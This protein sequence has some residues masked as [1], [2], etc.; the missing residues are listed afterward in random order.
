MS[1]KAKRVLSG[2]KLT[3][4]LPIQ[5]RNLIRENETLRNQ[6]A[7]LLK[8]NGE[9]H[10]ELK[11]TKNHFEKQITVLEA[12]ENASSNRI[13][14]VMHQISSVTKASKQTRIPSQSSS[15]E[16]LADNHRDRKSVV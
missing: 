11:Q 9:F 16:V 12:K 15:K 14:D 3:A 7:D 5:I 1:N 2:I 10:E 13:S 8:R 6:V 4:T